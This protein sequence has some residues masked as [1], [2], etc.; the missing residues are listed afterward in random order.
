[1]RKEKLV[2]RSFTYKW[3]TVLGFNNE[4]SDTEKKQFPVP[5]K[6]DDKKV[7]DYVRKVLLKDDDSTFV[8][9][10]LLDVEFKT[11]L[12][13]MNESTFLANSHIIPNRF[14]ANEITE[15]SEN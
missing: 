14:N 11:E 13:G 6:L 9:V 8:P 7:L 4:T 12:R 3:A 15:E 10:K 5:T 2:T 1:M